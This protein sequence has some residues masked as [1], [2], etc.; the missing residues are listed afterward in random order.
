MSESRGSL[1][2]SSN[3]EQAILDAIFGERDALYSHPESCR[4]YARLMALGIAAS[5]EAETTRALK[6]EADL[7]SE[8]KTLQ[9]IL[10]G[11]VPEKMGKI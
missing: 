11:P 5:V 7:K 1:V 2:I 3:L 4:N 10:A 6:V 8:I 9:A